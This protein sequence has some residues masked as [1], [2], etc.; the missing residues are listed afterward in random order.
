VTSGLLSGS[1]GNRLAIELYI[2]SQIVLRCIMDL[3]DLATYCCAAVS[4]C[5]CVRVCGWVRGCGCLARVAVSSFVFATTH[6]GN[7]L[8][9]THSSC[10][11]HIHT[12]IIIHNMSVAISCVR[13][14]AGSS[15]RAGKHAQQWRRYRW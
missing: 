5:V 9:S 2:E 3:L 8:I 4:V 15:D 12:M 14:S 13:T 10:R 1:E 7:L 6:I 11:F